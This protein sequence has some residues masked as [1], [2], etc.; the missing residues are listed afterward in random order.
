MDAL[1][2][3]AEWKGYRSFNSRSRIGF[4]RFMIDH[5]RQNRAS[6]AMLTVLHT[7]R[8]VWNSRDTETVTDTTFASTSE[9]FLNVGQW[10]RF[11]TNASIEFERYKHFGRPNTFL[12]MG[13][14]ASNREYQF[15]DLT[16]RGDFVRVIWPSHVAEWNRLRDIAN[17][18]LTP[19]PEQRVLRSWP[20]ARERQARETSYGHTVGRNFHA[21]SDATRLPIVHRSPEGGKFFGIELEFELGQ[22]SR[23]DGVGI[24]R[25]SWLES[26]CDIK[27]D[28]SLHDGLEIA[29]QPMTLEYFR[30]LNLD[31]LEQLRANGARAWDTTT[32]GVHIHLSRGN[33]SSDAHMWRFSKFIYGNRTQMRRIVGR[34][35]S[36]YVAW[37]ESDFARVSDVLKGVRYAATG[38]YSAVNLD[39]VATVEVRVFRSTL[40]EQTLRRYVDFVHALVDYTR[41]ISVK[42][43]ALGAL[44]F[45]AFT[46]WLSSTDQYAALTDSIRFVTREVA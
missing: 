3:Y 39:N 21:I 17:N 32:C 22:M 8:E 27:R 15:D 11:W 19:L 38:H 35:E 29:T 33:F 46:A 26:F 18:Y 10:S 28:G 13:Y 40:R 44:D 23:A 41:E 9:N 1:R 30:Q 24:V 34:D 2:F 14:F 31:V 37:R 36:Q 4:E 20:P 25:N 43:V 45:H 7:S 16:T 6:A 5:L 12:P 42:Q